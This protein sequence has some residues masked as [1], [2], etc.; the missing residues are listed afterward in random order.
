MAQPSY[1]IEYLGSVKALSGTTVT[2]ASVLALFPTATVL[3]MK[4]PDVKVSIN[5]GEQFDVDYNDE[6]FLTTGKSYM[7]NKDC[8]IAVGI[9]KA[10]V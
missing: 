8:I 4:T 9:Y 3:K 1:A 5:G 10:I 7:F 2:S 6:S